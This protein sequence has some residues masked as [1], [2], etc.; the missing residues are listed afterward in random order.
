MQMCSLWEWEGR[1]SLESS[2][3][4]GCERLLGPK[5]VFLAKI[6]NSGEGT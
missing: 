5:E 6:S 1:D 2:R 3:D 4:L